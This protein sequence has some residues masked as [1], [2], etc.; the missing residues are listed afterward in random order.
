MG[1]NHLAEDLRQY[2]P[3]DLCRSVEADSLCPL[4][5]QAL[6]LGIGLLAFDYA[7]VGRHFV[8]HSFGV[9]RILCDGCPLRSMGAQ[10]GRMKGSTFE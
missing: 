2:L 1:A 5:W 8:V 3:G 9:E 6:V 4:I 7:V 10:V